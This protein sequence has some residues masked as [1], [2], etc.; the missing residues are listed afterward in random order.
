[1]RAVRTWLVGL[2]LVVGCNHHVYSPPARALPLEAP[3]TL[4]QGGQAVRLSGGMH[5]EL[6]FGPN[7]PHG[8][9]T[10]RRALGPR[11]EL[12]GT[13][14]IAW[15][16]EPTQ[17]GVTGSGALGHLG[18]KLQLDEG[19]HVALRGG[20]GGGAHGAGMLAAADVGVIAGF[21]NRWV[22]PWIAI[23]LMGSQP[24]SARTVET[25]GPGSTMSDPRRPDTTGG[26]DL[27]GG[28]AISLGD[29]VRLHAGGGYLHLDDGDRPAG[30]VH[31]QFGLELLLL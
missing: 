12:S 27:G 23:T 26:F 3:A 6:T 15:V 22:V 9:L 11:L 17:E 21:Q 7:L 19:G 1:M 29:A 8:E 28:L 30:F 18:V 4:P 13:G 16:D 2:V 5:G 31:L 10:Y 14:T 25:A 24:I 20:L